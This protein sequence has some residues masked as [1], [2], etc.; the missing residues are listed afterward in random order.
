MNNQTSNVA[1]T[2]GGLMSLTGG[3]SLR[4][5]IATGYL[6]V[7]PFP[8][9]S[10]S[11]FSEG[12]GQSVGLKDPQR[13]G[14]AVGAESAV[15]LLDREYPHPPSETARTESLGVVLAPSW[16][17]GLR[18]SI[19]YTR[20]DTSGGITD[21]GTELQQYILD[22]ESAYPGRVVRAP[23]TAVDAA[24]GYTVGVITSL[25]YS[26]LTVARS[27]IDSVHIDLSYRRQTRIG[28]FR[29]Q[30][31]ATWE[32]D[33]RLLDDPTKPTYDIAGYSDGPLKWRGNLGID[34]TR[35][36]W[37]AALNAQIYGSYHDAVG[38][39]EYQTENGPALIAQ[40]ASSIPAQAYIDAVVSYRANYRLNGGGDHAIEYRFGIRNIFDWTPPA[41]I[42]P[43][44]IFETVGY[45]PY[46]DPRGR[47][48]EFTAT[49]H[50]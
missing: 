3:M 1:F 24:A 40:G 18:L 4:A 29:I 45:S 39:P 21:A 17:A 5:S 15:T 19:D 2:F 48:F 25:D 32:P 38:N 37:T 50:F 49:A 31:Q 33:F 26:E 13:G 43:P 9:L 34:W 11:T 36:R 8:D 27:S 35:D 6:P 41:V 30:G 46:G 28:A 47:R 14:Q 42:G 10:T 20:T 7:T 23:L 12:A 22:H 16:A 44:S